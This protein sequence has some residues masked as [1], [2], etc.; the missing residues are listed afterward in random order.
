MLLLL[1][2]LSCGGSGGTT[3]LQE[4]KIT[5]KGDAGTVFPNG[6]GIR[7][8]SISPEAT[9]KSSTPGFGVTVTVEGD[10]TEQEKKDLST[11]FSVNSNEQRKLKFDSSSLYLE[12]FIGEDGSVKSIVRNTVALTDVETNGSVTTLIVNKDPES[13]YIE[14][15][16]VNQIGTINNEPYYTFSQEIIMDEGKKMIYDDDHSNKIVES[17]NPKKGATKVIFESNV[18]FVLVNVDSEDDI[19]TNEAFRAIQNIT[20]ENTEFKTLKLI[21]KDGTVIDDTNQNE[22]IKEAIKQ[23]I[24]KLLSMEIEGE[25]DDNRYEGT[26]TLDNLDKWN[27][28]GNINIWRNFEK[29]VAYSQIFK[30]EGQVLDIVLTIDN[31]HSTLGNK[32]LNTIKI[33]SARGIKVENNSLVLSDDNSS[34]RYIEATVLSDIAE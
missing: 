24:T 8:L 22:V 27:I 28:E 29:S 10:L 12:Y 7:M 34:Y 15:L 33:D 1:L 31:W 13:G 20:E 16:N 17:S 9:V 26:L 19:P 14:K 5:A 25:G 30:E 2:L 6:T 11:L 21:T 32:S 3:P 4:N 18:K 23:I